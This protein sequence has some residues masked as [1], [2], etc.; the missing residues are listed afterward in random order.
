MK[1]TAEEDS[2]TQR[3][4]DSLNLPPNTR[5]LLLPSSSQ[6]LMRRGKLEVVVPN[7]FI[8]NMLKKKYLPEITRVARE[9][10]EISSVKITADESRYKELV[11]KQK[12]KTRSRV[13]SPQKPKTRRP[14]YSDFATGKSRIILPYREGFGDIVSHK[15]NKI[16]LEET[17][18]LVQRVLETGHST[19]K[20]CLVGPQ[21]VGKTLIIAALMDELLKEKYLPAYLQLETLARDFRQ[22]SI[23]ANTTD[24]KWKAPN[25]LIEAQRKKWSLLTLDYLNGLINPKAKL[26]EH[27][28]R[29][30]GQKNVLELWNFALDHQLPITT[31]YTGTTKGF[32]KL[33]DKVKEGTPDLAD[34][35]SELELIQIA[36]PNEEDRKDFIKELI[37]KT[38]KAP[39]DEELERIAQHLDT[40]IPRGTSIRRIKGQYIG[41]ISRASAKEPINYDTTKKLVGTQYDLFGPTEI[42]TE[43]DPYK[44]LATAKI[45]FPGIIP[46]AITSKSRKREVVE[47]RNVLMF[48]MQKL[49]GLTLKEIGRLFARDH[50]TV[51]NSLS[52]INSLTEDQ[53]NQLLKDVT[54]ALPENER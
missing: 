21:G 54:D 43:I 27:V 36:P 19:D 29:P 10:L 39:N 1:E 9:Q 52:K 45:L 22:A 48:A 33:I 6:L 24:H 51:I 17:S 30:G 23:E 41:T 8:G 37:K 18:K 2:D 40:M 5:S 32:Q 12:I 49:A 13:S 34:R 50:T 42:S 20:I 7:D 38:G 31:S 16:A 3:V 15:G 26:K 53:R 14:T 28:Q 35:M 4:Y 46:S 11:P 47:A 25:Y 44:I